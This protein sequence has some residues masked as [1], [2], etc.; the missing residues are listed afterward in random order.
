MKRAYTR[1]LL[2]LTLVAFGTISAFSQNT[3]NVGIGIFTPNPKAILDVSSDSLGMLAPRLSTLQRIGIL[4]GTN[5]FGLFVY[6]T[7]LDGFYYWDGTQWLPMGSGTGGSTG[8]TGPTG[9]TG[10][11]GSNG[12][13]GPTGAPGASGSNGATGPTGPSGTDGVTGPSGTDGATGPTGPSGGP[14]GPTGPTGATGSN[15]SAGSTGPT[16]PTGSGT[17]GATG[18]TG[19]TG[20]NG[21]AGSTGPTGPTG[22]GTTGATGPTGPTGNNG[23]AGATGPTGPTGSGTTG[24]TGPTGP[25]GSGGGGVLAEAIG[26]TDIS[27]AATGSASY[28]NMAGMSVSFTP[29]QST[30]YVSF[31]ASGGYSFTNPTPGCLVRFQVLVNSTPVNGRGAIFPVGSYDAIT[32]EGHNVWGAA[33]EVPI[34]VNANVSNTVTIQWS[35]E[36]F[37]VNTIYC[38]PTASTSQHRSLIVR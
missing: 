30:A 16:G 18:P 26:S 4:P 5:D 1:I 35:F 10:L 21:S 27:K 3:A 22:S 17:T 8:P 23:S 25:T 37:Y 11:A 20:N 9:P 13:T 2:S 36:S 33:F 34:T 24:A 15:G 19:P 32:G 6:D 12:A 14:A 38:N 28:A 29:T 31:S 7:D